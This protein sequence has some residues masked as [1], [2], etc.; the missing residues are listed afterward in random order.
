M[1][2]YAGNETY[3][4]PAYRAQR[5]E[6]EHDYNLFSG[7]EHVSEIINALPY[8]AA[9]LNRERQLVFGNRKLLEAMGFEKFEEI[10]GLRPGELMN[11]IHSGKTPGGCGTSEACRHCGAVNAIMECLN[12][13]NKVMNDCR[14][15]A[16]VGDREISFD[17]EITASPFWYQ[18]SEFVVLSFKDIS[19]EKRRMVLEKLFFHDILNTAGGLRGFI[20]F[21]EE[22][23]N[24]EES[25]QYIKTVSR[26][27]DILIEEIQAHRQLLAAERGSLEADFKLISIK[28]IVKETVSQLSHHDV[29]Q[30]KEIVIEETG[31]DVLLETDPVL[32]KRVLLNLMKN[33]VEASLSGQSITIGYKTTGHELHLWVINDTVMPRDIQLQV[34]QRSFS[35]KGKSRGIGTYSIKLFT[36]QYL[37]GRVEF[38]SNDQVRTRFTICLPLKQS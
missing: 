10:I 38:V 28:Q 34:F 9:V 27:S 8:I 16:T 6:V 33:A 7:F 26:L 32:L 1:T 5:L 30:N 15:T 2:D 35:T 23:E 37:N 19:D 3:Y 36:E 12:T 24:P 31:A 17:F 14:I 13:G 22:T 25:R 4:A 18:E 11:C 21:I 20:E 29:S